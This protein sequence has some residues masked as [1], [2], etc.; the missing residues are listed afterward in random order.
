MCDI[1]RKAREMGVYTVVTDWY[2]N[3]PAKQLADKAYMVSTSD[4]DA[5]V[6]LIREERIDGVFTGYIDST[7]PYYYEICQKAGLPCYLTSATLECCTNKQTFKQVCKKV[8]LLTIPE[9]DLKNPGMLEYPVLIKPVDNSGS[10]GI[11]V[12]CDESV[13][14]KAKVH[15]LR[16]S[17]SKGYI[18][19]RFMNCDYV[20]AYYA[21]RNGR[22][23]VSMLMDK[24]M[25]RIGRGAVPYPTALVCPSRYDRKYM[26]YVHPLVQRLIDQLGF[27]NGTFL[28]SFFVNGNYFYAVE[29]TA[30]LAATREYLFI[31]DNT[32]EDLL[33]A[34]ICHA[35]TGVFPSI[36]LTENISREQG[37]RVYC[38]LFLFIREG[39]IGRIEGME[40]I[41]GMRGVLDVLQLRSCGAKIR[42]DGSYGQL[43]AR[44]Y[45]KTVKKDE[46]VELVDK[47][48]SLLHV[49]SEDG[50]QMLV[51]GFDAGRFFL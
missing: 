37:S 45:L 15:A 44:I 11:T 1:V 18:A 46:M 42:A 9:A 2:E 8:G 19:E 16:F 28:I 39:I 4:V 20:A 7:L 17:K 25:N 32:G 36:K 10:K 27:Q 13:I 26:K 22:A 38:M 51:T 43:F 3:S 23:E 35:L 21:V 14:E 34:H 49:Y 33:A 41:M 47:I 12:C 24:D 50:K 40:K 30:R 31:Q 29:L 5:V 6:H 48:R